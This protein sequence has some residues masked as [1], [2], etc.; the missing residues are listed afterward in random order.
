M[1]SGFWRQQLA[2]TLPLWALK[3]GGLNKIA[4]N[5]PATFLKKVF[6]KE[7]FCSLIQILRKFVPNGPF[8]NAAA[9]VKVM[10][11]HF[12]GAKPLTEPMLMHT[13]ITVSWILKGRLLTAEI[14]SELSKWPNLTNSDYK[15]LTCPN[16]AWIGLMLSPLAPWNSI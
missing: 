15:A 5:I 1:P 10:A 13:C 16:R 12:S 6:Y 9:S 7:F 14:T 2:S 3:H 11:C 8:N 4:D